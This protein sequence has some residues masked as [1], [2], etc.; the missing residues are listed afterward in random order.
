MRRTRQ[1]REI[2]LA[3]VDLYRQ[4]NGDPLSQWLTCVKFKI[5]LRLVERR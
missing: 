1:I 4:K 3:I 2:L 5:F